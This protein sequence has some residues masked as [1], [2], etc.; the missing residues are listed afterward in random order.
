MIFE[1]V[2]AL[3]VPAQVARDAIADL[4]KT[5]PAHDAYLADLPCMTQI[6]LG[7]EAA[8]TRLGFPFTI[9][10]WNLERCLF[11]KASADLI[12]ATGAAVVLLSEMDNGMSRTAQNHT[13]AVL[14]ADLGMAYAYGVEFLEL[15]LGSETER[16]FCR[17]AFNEK[18]FH[19]NALTAAVALDQPFMLRLAG[20]RHWFLQG[21]DQPR[22]GERMAV[23]AVIQTEAGPMIVVSTHLESVADAAGRALQITGLIDALETQFPGLPVV[24]GGDLN[25]GNHIGGDFRDE[26]LFAQAIARGFSVHGGPET[27]MTT[28]ASLI[29]RWPERAMKLDW[30]LTRGVVIDAV[31]IIP[32]LDAE[33]R[34]LSDHDLITC[35]IKSVLSGNFVKT[36]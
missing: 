15:G 26:T 10:A 25:T 14:A 30:F 13:T 8:E 7:G 11:P 4:P 12:R 34:P 24:I 29:T 18:G 35:S 21:G 27:T 22:L 9:G 6:E 33:G 17:D 36:A 20:Q 1:T 32:S 3:P 5:L 31:Q 19:G 28:R 16:A 2:A 23:G